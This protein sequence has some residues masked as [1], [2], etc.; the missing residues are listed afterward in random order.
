MI[1]NES[2]DLDSAVSAIGLA[3]H[4]TNHKPLIDIQHTD[5]F[6]PVLNVAREKLPLK[7]E[8]IHFLEQNEILADNLICRDEVDVNSFPSYV[9][10]DHHVSPFD[11]QKIKM[12]FDHRPRNPDVQFHP[13]A[14]IDI[15][16]VGSCAT[17]IGHYILQESTN[18]TDDE[19]GV[20]KLL[21]GPIILDTINF[22]P[23]A[24]KA[25]PLDSEVL[26]KMESILEVH[27]LSYRTKLFD[28]LVAAR[29]DV[30]SLDSYQILFKDMKVIGERMRFAIPGYPIRV[31]EY[32]QMVN[33]ESNVL[34][35]ARE[36]N[37]D[38]VVMM[39]MKIVDGNVL[40][41]L[42]IVN[43]NNGELFAQCKERLENN[44]QFRFE[45]VTTF[46]GG[47]VYEQGNIKLSRKQIMPILN[48]LLLN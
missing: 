13:R 32:I 20:L 9:L 47:P 37:C 33:A 12:V 4:L 25:R 30:S 1:G 41:D 5:Y 28:E 2:C 3:Y 23:D 22:S 15:R 21:S 19:K 34:R 24:D 14:L 27:D 44:T 36:L 38:V 45:Q 10:V 35:F 18:S 16:E 42:A 48:Q 11:P 26:A 29:C 6:I 31:Q 40:R 39:G 8:V 46:L 43:I 7:S 17:L